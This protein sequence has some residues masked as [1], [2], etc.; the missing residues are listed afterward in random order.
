[1]QIRP[2]IGFWWRQGDQ[3]MKL[4]GKGGSGE[5]STLFLEILHA[6]VPIVKKHWPA[7]NE[8]NLLDDAVETLSE[9]LTP[10][11]P[12]SKNDAATLSNQ[13]M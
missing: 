8:N 5:G 6:N 9:V 2:L 10:V 1:M 12:I 11:P 7:L 13:Q 4:I 3:I